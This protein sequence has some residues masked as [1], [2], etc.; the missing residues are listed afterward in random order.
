MTTRAPRIMAVSSLGFFI[1]KTKTNLVGGF[2]SHLNIKDILLAMSFHDRN[3]LQSL[4]L[5]IFVPDLLS[6]ATFHKEKQE[7][8]TVID[9]LF[10]VGEVGAGGRGQGVGPDI[11]K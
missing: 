4:F 1:H 2:S 3:I 9:C 5:F 11:F 7:P 6:N 8:H 10:L